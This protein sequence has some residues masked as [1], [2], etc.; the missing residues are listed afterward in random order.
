LPGLRGGPQASMSDLNMTVEQ[1]KSQG[2][3]LLDHHRHANAIVH[4]DTAHKERLYIQAQKN[5]YETVKNDLIGSVGGNRGFTILGND[6]T[7]VQHYQ[8]TEV[9]NDR[10][11][12]V[13][14]D[15][16]HF[17]KGNILQ[18]GQKDS[19]TITPL[20][21]QSYGAKTSIV[22]FAEDKKIELQVGQESTILMHP[23]VIAIQSKEVYINP[24]KTFMA[25][26]ANGASVKDAKDAQDKRDADAA[27]RIAANNKKL[28]SLKQDLST[29]QIHLMNQQRLAGQAQ[30]AAQMYPND[31]DAQDNAKYWQ[32][33]ADQT[34]GQ[35]NNINQQT[36]ALNAENASLKEGS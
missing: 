34:Q 24:G 22:L 23:D 30:S 7:R 6:T 14:G 1:L 31:Q 18:Q 15:Q 8:V 9:G 27:A 3:D 25:A 29:A 36:N 19:V 13:G 2:P 21:G 5:L 10:S 11:V 28:D 16:T 33:R 20:G 32:G 26:L 17:V 35:I 4:D 12:A